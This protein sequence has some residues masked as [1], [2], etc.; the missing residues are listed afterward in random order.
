M[1]HANNCNAIIEPNTCN[2]CE[3]EVISKAALKKHMPGC[4]G[5]KQREACRNCESCRYHKANRCLFFHPSKGQNQA[6]NWP[7]QQPSQ[8]NQN[9]QPPRRQTASQAIRCTTRSGQQFSVKIE[10]H[11]G[12]VTSVAKIYSIEKQVGAMG[13][14][15]EPGTVNL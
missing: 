8:E 4:Q 12:L 3:R 1:M 14:Y 6:N 11:Y 9:N 7:H 2:K 10:T 13:A 15:A 5:K